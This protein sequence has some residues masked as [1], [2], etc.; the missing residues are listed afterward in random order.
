[1]TVA[2]GLKEREKGEKKKEGGFVVMLKSRR[3]TVG[4]DVLSRRFKNED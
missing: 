3:A 2:S 1:M 4:A